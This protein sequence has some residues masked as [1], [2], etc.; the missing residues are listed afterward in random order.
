MPPAGITVAGAPWAG[1]AAK[2]AVAGSIHVEV[3][4]GEV[5]A[6]GGESVLA[7]LKAVLH[8]A[9]CSV[10]P[11]EAGEVDVATSTLDAGAHWV[12]FG[13][14][15]VG[16]PASDAAA[17]GAVVEAVCTLPPA[18]VHVRFLCPP[19]RAPAGAGGEAG[20]GAVAAS[21]S[22]SA[23]PAAATAP[24]T[25]SHA[26]MDAVTAAIG[27]LHSYAC[28]FEV[29]ASAGTLSS[30]DAKALKAAV[31]EQRLI[32]HLAGGRATAKEVARLHKHEIG[33]QAHAA[34]AATSEAV[35]R[36]EAVGV[37]DVGTC[38]VACARSDRPDGLYT[39]VVSDESGKTLGL[40]YSSADSILEAIRSRRGVYYSRSRGGLWRKGDTSG[41][42]QALRC[43]KLDCDSDA[44]L[45]IVKQM[46]AVP[47]FCHLNTRTCWGEDGGVTALEV[48]LPSTPRRPTFP[49]PHPP[50]ATRP[51]RTQFAPPPTPPPSCAAHPGV[52]PRRRA[53]RLLHQ[54]PV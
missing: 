52:P 47:A 12:V 36:G 54:A 29:P 3:P 40:V 22:H 51:Q 43:I 34:V 6:A 48:R 53:T 20:T 9:P 21:P 11:F 37:L 33:L 15:L 7:R 25:A 13:L 16:V 28:A 2:L 5:A 49:R 23:S 32:L 50:H 38:L 27:A 46:G 19:L 26:V 17:L 24:A 42:W 1:E 30:D 41:C 8:E 44:L 14:P 4:A 18:R 45:Y 39:T 35:E 10:G 31:G